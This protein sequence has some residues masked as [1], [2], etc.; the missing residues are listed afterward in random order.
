M[1]SREELI[2]LLGLTDEQALA[3]LLPDR[4][5][6]LPKEPLTPGDGGRITSSAR[7]DVRLAQAEY[8]AAA[9]AQGLQVLTSFTDIELGGRYDT[10]KDNTDGHKIIKRGYE[11]SLRL[12]FFD[13]GDAQRDA[14]N[15]LTLAA[16]NPMM[17]GDGPLGSVEM[18]GMFSVVK[19]RKEQ[20]AG[21][22]SNPGWYKH[23]PG[24][25]A[26][27]YTGPTAEPAR[28]KAE[29]GQSMPLEQKTGKE[30]DLKIRKPTG[31]SGH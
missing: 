31:H 8:E 3:L 27:E 13:R 28:F 1:S 21:D 19:V 18:G 15:A 4:L 20:K 25:L 11:V 29:P 24:T 7:L 30:I 14:M 9:K 16:A 10:I 17:T 12:P 6:D 2:R 26:F 5:P 23:P 22:Y